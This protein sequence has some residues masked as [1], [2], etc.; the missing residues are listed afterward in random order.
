MNDTLEI[1]AVGKGAHAST[2]H[3]G[4]NALTAL[5]KLIAKLPFADCEQIKMLHSLEALF[6]WDDTSGRAL[7]IAMKDELSGELTLAFSLL[8]V[9]EDSLEGTFDSRCPICANEK[10]VLIPVREKLLQ[11]GLT[12]TN[13]SMRPSH[14]VDGNSE[15][16]KTLN[17]AY[18]RYTG[19]KG[20]VESMGGGTYVHDLKN[21]VAFGASLPGT[22]NN[23]HGADE[24]AVI[25]E[26]LIS[27]KIFAQ[28]IADLCK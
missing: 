26:L 9:T 12:L 16:V 11:H 18:E 25:D 8:E 20:G 6:P 7:G 24:F 17:N 22:D 28:V 15:F 5:L 13:D 14:H 1:T 4:K 2:P 23:M 21:G 27:A 19:L 3:E 10:N